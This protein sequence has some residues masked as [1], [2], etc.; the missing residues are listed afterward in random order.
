MKRKTDNAR[1]Q[2]KK[3]VSHVV[4]GGGGVG[5]YGHR[6][7]AEVAKRPKKGCKI[8]QLK[9]SS[10]F[11]NM[12]LNQKGCLSILQL[13]ENFLTP[14]SAYPKPCVGPRAPACLAHFQLRHPLRTSAPN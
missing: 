11:S 12:I 6:Y 7:S 9:I 5:H 13:T 8:A 4:S 2:I 14:P 1:K 3:K 10:Y